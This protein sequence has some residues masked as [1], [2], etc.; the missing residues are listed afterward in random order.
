MRKLGKNQ[1]RIINGLALGMEF[2]GDEDIKTAL[3]LEQLGLL[4][5]GKIKE[6]KGTFTTM[7]GFKK[8]RY[9]CRMQD[10]TLTDLG[11]SKAIL[12]L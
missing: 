4:K 11:K 5:L 8:H 7:K 9:T 10:A 3:R 2:V 6:K 1:Q 12:I